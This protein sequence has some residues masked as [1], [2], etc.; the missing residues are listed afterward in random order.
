[1]EVVE[2][3]IENS[4]ALELIFDANLAYEILR[5]ENWHFATLCNGV[6]CTKGK[7]DAAC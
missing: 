5:T 2:Y 4:E 7:V 6:H 1:M 3:T